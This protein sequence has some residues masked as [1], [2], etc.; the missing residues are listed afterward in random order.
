MNSITQKATLLLVDDEPL[1][2]E[3][4]AQWLRLS[5][6]EVEE[7]DNAQTLLNRFEA[8]DNVIVIS[9][10]RMQP[11]DGLGLM[12]QLL[13]LAPKLPVILI[14][15]HGDIDMAVKALRDGAFDFLEKPF[16][17]NRLL[18]TVNKASAQR[19]LDE[20]HKQQQDYLAN[21]KGIEELILGKSVEIQAIREQ[22]KTF[23]QIDTNVIIYGDTGCGKELVAQALH[24]HS[25][26]QSEPFIAINCAAIP[27]DLFESELFGHEAGAFTSAQK[28][29]IGKLELASGGSLFLDEIESMPLAMQIKL[30][31]VLQ[32]NTLERV[33]GNKSIK[34]DLRVLAAAKGN[35][36]TQEAFRQD[37]FFRLNVS[38]VHLPPLCERG[39]DIPLLFEHFCQQ[40]CHE[41]DVTFRQLSPM[42]HETLMLYGWP[43]NVR[44]LRNVALRYALEANSTVAKILSGYQAQSSHVNLSPLPLS[45]KVQEYERSLIDQTL[46]DCKGN[47][48]QALDSLQLPR[49]TLN[50]K[51]QR[52]G[53]NRSDYL[54]EG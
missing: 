36:Q 6:Y 27:A 28:Q 30:L 39:D 42:D 1:V 43:G 4:T 46:K 17:P 10:I 38:Q 35:L 40:A 7:F 12:S 51:M 2:R 54:D 20:Q 48:Q 16:D 34:V 29:R 13:Q 37:L 47:I 9:D 52:Y 53:L 31:R 21:V 8:N 22:I 26:R 44:E 15:G 50:Q 18:E 24:E 32:E 45:V 19:Q 23:A 3:T 5:D 49:R 41:K 14:T 25:H 33:G 11:L